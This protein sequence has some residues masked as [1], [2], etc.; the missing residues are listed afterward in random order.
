MNV[1]R[2]LIHSVNFHSV[3]LPPTEKIVFVATGRLVTPQLIR[4]LP[5]VSIISRHLFFNSLQLIPLFV[6][7]RC[8]LVSQN[9]YRVIALSGNFSWSIIELLQS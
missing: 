9:L 3:R 5:V 2:Y 8:I 7:F 4:E 1:T 6:S